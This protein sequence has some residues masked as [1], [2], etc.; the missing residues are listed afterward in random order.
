V[1]AGKLFVN[2]IESPSASDREVDRSEGK[3]LRA[4]LDLAELPHLYSLVSNYR[5]FM[6]ALGE[7]TVNPIARDRVPVIHLSMHGSPAGLVLT[8]GH[9]LPWADLN[10]KFRMINGKLNHTLFVCL[11]S[12]YGLSGLQMIR[13]ETYG[14]LENHPPFRLLVSNLDRVPW[15]DAAIGFSAFYHLLERGRN[16]LEMVNAMRVASGND[17]FFGL[18]AGDEPTEQLIVLGSDQLRKAID[19]V[20]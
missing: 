3:M 8:D 9:F 5:E 20:A 14:G 6:A 11:S 17:R 1:F 15:S 13:Q 16:P 2:I 18:L 4:A 12:C 19:G 7:W 10:W